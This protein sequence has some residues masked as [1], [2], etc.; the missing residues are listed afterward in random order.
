MAR[1]CRGDARC[2][3]KPR[4]LHHLSSISISALR[5][6]DAA[7][8]T[9]PV[10]TGAQYSY[11]EI[12]IIPRDSTLAAPTPT[13]TPTQYLDRSCATTQNDAVSTRFPPITEPTSKWL[14]ACISTEEHSFTAFGIEEYTGYTRQNKNFQE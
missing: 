14:R 9:R 8:E 2:A 13:P 4:H 11:L 3:R 1:D 7:K 10:Q 5:S 12:A 6:D